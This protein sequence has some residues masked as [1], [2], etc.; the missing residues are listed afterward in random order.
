MNQNKVENV[1]I[2]IFNEKRDME[3]VKKLEENCEMGSKKGVSMFTSNM[4]GHPLCRIR[5]YLVHVM[6]V[7]G[8]ISYFTL[9]LFLPVDIIEHGT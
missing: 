2:R 5:L 3:V 4:M 7:G 8:M 1:V 9:I 6:L